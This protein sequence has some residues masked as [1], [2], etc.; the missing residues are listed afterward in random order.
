MSKNA[1]SLINDNECI[2]IEVTGH[3]VWSSMNALLSN[4]SVLSSFFL[5][6]PKHLLTHSLLRRHTTGTA[7]KSILDL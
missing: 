2:G 6:F 5:P 1:L 4:L 7:A 3:T